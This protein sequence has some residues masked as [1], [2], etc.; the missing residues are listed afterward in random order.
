MQTLPLMMDIQPKGYKYILMLWFT[1]FE[2]GYGKTGYVK[3]F[4]YL[5]GFGSAFSNTP[6]TLTFIV[7][8]LYGIGCF[9]GGWLWFKLRLY[10][11]QAEVGNQYNPFVREMRK[12]YKS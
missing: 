6:L 12:V 11:Y 2:T 9:I 10:D 5:M 1:Y 3:I 7:A 8:G 4:I